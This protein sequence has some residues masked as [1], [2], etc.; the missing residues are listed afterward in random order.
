[1]PTPVAYPLIQGVRH[2]WTSLDFKVDTTSYFGLKSLDWSDGLEPGDVYGVGAQKQ[3]RTR[4]VYSADAGMEFYF[5]DAIALEQQLIGK[6]QGGLY[7][8]SFNISVNVQSEGGMP[9]WTVAI[10]GARITKRT[11]SGV[12]A[13]GSDP[14]AYKYDLNVMNVM[15][16]KVAPFT[17]F[18][19]Q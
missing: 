18:R 8:V 10:R 14:L 13:G 3:G 7:E 12:A 4:G 16:N 11:P 17:G 1:M 15:Q 9:P 5:A 19:Q 6:G 2:D